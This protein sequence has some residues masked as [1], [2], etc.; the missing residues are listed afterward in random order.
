VV[1]LKAAAAPLGNGRQD[2][3]VVAEFRW[4]AEARTHVHHREAGN[5]EGL[6]QL[7]LAIAERFEHADGAD[8]EELEIAWEIDDAGGVAV[9]PL[10]T[11][12]AR[13]SQQNASPD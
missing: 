6:Q 3:H 7:R 4:D 1:D 12:F 10:D 9:A 2:D 11:N 8:I 13:N 5:V